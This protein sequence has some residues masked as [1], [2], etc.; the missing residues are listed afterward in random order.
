MGCLIYH[1]DE[2][3]L[4]SK[5]E[6][7]RLSRSYAEAKMCSISNRCQYGSVSGSSKVA[8]QTGQR[9]LYVD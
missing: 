3:D 7:A 9:C 1:C 5:D 4:V 8:V 6:P 2:L